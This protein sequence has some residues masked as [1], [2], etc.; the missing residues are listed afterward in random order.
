MHD[1]NVHRL[2]G[3]LGVHLARLHFAFRG[4]PVA[5]VA[6]QPLLYT[7]GTVCVV[8]LRRHATEHSRAA[9]LANHH[10]HVLGTD[11]LQL[12]REQYELDDCLHGVSCVLLRCCS[13]ITIA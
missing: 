3:A 10:G 9:F 13:V 1:H 6:F 11:A 5:Q 8:L 4:M 2:R 12:E 7:H